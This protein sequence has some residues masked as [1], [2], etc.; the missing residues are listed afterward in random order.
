MVIWYQVLLSNAIYKLIS[1]T[2]S[3]DLDR[4]YRLRIRVELGINGNEMSNSLLHWAPP[5]AI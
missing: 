4:Y 1:L 3:W 2:H 5:D